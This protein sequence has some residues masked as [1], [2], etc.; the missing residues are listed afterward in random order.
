MPDFVRSAS[1]ANPLP[2]EYL[3][4]LR[5]ELG[6]WLTTLG[7]RPGDVIDELAVVTADFLRN[8]KLDAGSHTAGHVKRDL[9]E[10]ATLPPDR[11]VARLMI[12]NEFALGVFFGEMPGASVELSI[13]GGEKHRRL[14]PE[15]GALL[16][17]A[18]K[19]LTRLGDKCMPATGL[20]YRRR[21]ETIA[22]RIPS[23]APPGEL[24]DF[25]AGLADIILEGSGTPAQ[26]TR[27]IGLIADRLVKVGSLGNV[28]VQTA[29]DTYFAE[30]DLP[31]QAAFIVEIVRPCLEDADAAGG[32]PNALAQLI[33]REFL[34]HVASS[35]RRQTLMLFARAFP[36]ALSNFARVLAEQIDS[37]YRLQKDA[38]SARRDARRWHKAHAG[39]RLIDAVLEIVWP[40]VAK[41]MG[42]RQREAVVEIV[43]GLIVFLDGADLQLRAGGDAA[44]RSIRTRERL[45]EE[46]RERADVANVAN[47]SVNIEHVAVLAALRSAIH[48][49]DTVLGVLDRRA[50]FELEPTSHKDPEARR[51][52]DELRRSIGVIQLWRRE[53]THK[54]QFG[55]YDRASLHEPRATGARIALPRMPQVKAEG[56]AENEAAI[57]KIVDAA[58]ALVPKNS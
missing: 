36:G 33:F 26:K 1:R 18:S 30:L 6:P 8:R 12:L 54:R 38:R 42:P 24:A 55:E 9:L 48:K 25:V 34:V 3:A 52:L 32:R 5:E 10:L 43:R 21:A 40:D 4:E 7:L 45:T 22:D 15:D 19:T 56:L 57:R 46:G 31:G 37:Q 39:W 58:Q 53:L 35:E 27:R 13:D 29:L 20:V 50:L 47:F 44:K 17:A 11:I 51:L 16:A 14:L 49:L 41:E 28:P 2:R 23:N